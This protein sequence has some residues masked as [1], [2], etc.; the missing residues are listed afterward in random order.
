MYNDQRNI[1]TK[2][3]VN[4]LK[5]SFLF[6]W[7]CGNRKDHKFSAII[8]CHVKAVLLSK[9]WSVMNA[10][11]KKQTMV[12]P[13]SLESHVLTRIEVVLTVLVCGAKV[14]LPRTTV[15]ILD[16]A[17]A[18]RCTG[19]EEPIEFWE[20][21]RVLSCSATLTTSITYRKIKSSLTQIWPPHNLVRWH[22]T[23]SKMN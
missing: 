7:I 10:L 20:E 5:H 3:V 14:C 17:A 2:L 4:T 16:S 18:L 12:S 13:W 6:P 9:W 21:G 22:N 8:L 11:T 19:E 23:K 15:V 1:F